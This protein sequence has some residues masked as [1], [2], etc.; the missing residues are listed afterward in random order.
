MHVGYF[1]LSLSTTTTTTATARSATRTP[2]IK[3]T[4]ETLARER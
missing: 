2:P 1:L 3:S 4:K